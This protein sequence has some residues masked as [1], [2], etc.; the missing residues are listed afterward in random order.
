LNS[1]ATGVKGSKKL[2]Y[3]YI[4]S[5]KRK[6]E[7]LHYLLVVAVNVTTE[8]KEKTE[9]LNAF[10]ICVFKSQTSYPQGT[11]LSDLEIS[12]GVQNKPSTI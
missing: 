4:N 9:I 3:K 6:K 8:D 7:N 12:D 2:Y 1:L 10:F 5:K 11:L